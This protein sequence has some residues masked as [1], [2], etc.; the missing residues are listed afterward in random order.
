MN[1]VVYNLLKQGKVI[2]WGALVML[3]STSTMANT[4]PDS[5]TAVVRWNKALLEAVSATG[6]GPTVVSRAL[7]IAHTCMFD[8]WAAYDEEARSTARGKPGKRPVAERTPENKAEAIS[9]AAYQAARNLFPQEQERF[10]ALLEDQG[11]ALQDIEQKVISHPAGMGNQACQNVLDRRRDDGSNQYGDLSPGA[12]SDYTG[13]QP[14]NTPDTLVDPNRF[15]PLRLIDD[16]GNVFVQSFL[17]P[18][19][20]KV[21]PFAMKNPRSYLLKEPAQYGTEAYVEQAL[22]AISY[23]ALLTDAQKMI[24]E[25]WADGP[26]TVTPPGH[27]NLFAQF[28]SVRDQY[29]LDEDVKMFFAL[30]NAVMDAGI[31]SWWAKRE[32][33]YI[34]PVSAIRHLFAGQMIE[35]WAGP[36]EYTGEIPG[37]EWQP[38]QKSSQ[39]TP[40]FAEYI[41][42]HSTFS[43]AAA[44]VLKQFTG[45]DVFGHKVYFAAGSSDFE[46]GMVPLYDME[47]TWATFTDAANEAGA[48]RRYGGIHFLDG[49]MEGR[50]TGREIGRLVWEKARYHFGYN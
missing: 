46:P 1:K 36:G 42:G 37:E 24:A 12:Y 22:E 34:R 50:R 27:W 39:L 29:G 20:G 33:D 5:E 26:N 32:Y 6:K 18:H 13:Y 3:L 45:S 7:G 43:A 35:A 11:Y 19:W 48:S 40:P 44:E 28:V 8:A 17:T 41:S 25:Y 14:V 4:Q 49:D 47:I 30:N 21:T 23:S 15:Q 38:Y 31:F 2:F 10:E 9:F 16:E